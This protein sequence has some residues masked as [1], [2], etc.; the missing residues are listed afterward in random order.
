MN[1]VTLVV[2]E[3][4]GH[5]ESHGKLLCL[6]NAQTTREQVEIV[7]GQLFFNI[8]SIQFVRFDFFRIPLHSLLHLSAVF[9]FATNT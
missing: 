5:N 3:L 4:R 8:S 2:V 7:V 6:L 1:G 9:V